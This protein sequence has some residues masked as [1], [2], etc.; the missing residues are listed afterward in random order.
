MMSSWWRFFTYVLETDLFLVTTQQASK[1][2]H[3]ST[4]ISISMNYPLAVPYGIVVEAYGESW[5]VDVS[6]ES[7][8]TKVILMLSYSRL[9]ELAT[10]T[11][12]FNLESGYSEVFTGMTT[13]LTLEILHPMGTKS[14]Q[15]YMYIGTES[16]FYALYEHT[17]SPF[18]KN[19]FGSTLL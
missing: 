13:R 16:E 10:T 7:P 15:S 19:E 17:Y 18:I 4:A 14:K 6:R 3:L 9:Y 5:G 2:Q 12:G 1:L 8:F 11:Y